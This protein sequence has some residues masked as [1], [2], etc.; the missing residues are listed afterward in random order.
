MFACSAHR[1]PPLSRSNKHLPSS[2]YVATTTTAGRAIHQMATNFRLPQCKRAPKV[3]AQSVKRIAHAKRQTDSF[4]GESSV[5]RFRRI[6]WQR[7]LKVWSEEIALK[8]YQKW[9]RMAH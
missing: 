2:F 7:R 3:A 6:D 9:T 4:W 8:C 5:S 1:A